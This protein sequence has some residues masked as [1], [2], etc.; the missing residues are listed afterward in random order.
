M[1]DATHSDPTP[2]QAAALV[3]LRSSQRILLTGHERPDGDCIGAQA[4]LSRILAQL[5]HEVTILNPDPPE[6][7]Y[8]Y[9][10][11]ACAYG[12]DDGG[13]LPAHD[14]LVL[15][16]CAELSRTGSLA[17]RFAAAPSRKMVLDHHVLPAEPW[18]DVAFHDVTASSTGLLVHRIAR[19]LSVELDAIAASGIF[20]SMVTDTGWFKYS[21]TDAETLAVA[22][23]L[24]HMGVAPHE[25]F[26]AIYQRRDAAHPRAVAGVL[27]RVA[28]HANGRLAVADLPLGPEGKPVQLDTEDVLDLLR[29]V[30]AVE[31]VLLVREIERGVC[32]L[33]ARSKS[34]YDVNALARRFG[35]GGHVKAS[36]ATIRGALGDVR[37]RLVAAAEEGFDAA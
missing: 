14:L 3:V 24:V 26:S 12:V 35:G 16:D 31:V 32:K 11:S 30:R 19:A 22:A 9:L 7:Q 5:G 10:S 33:S 6:P 34:T 27:E 17:E 13:A 25:L 28:Y 37:A 2:A 21:N 15:L 29:S 1:P 18:W 4:A 20:T 23:E 8:E 36:G